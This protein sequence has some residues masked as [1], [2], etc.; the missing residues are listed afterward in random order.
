[1]LVILFVVHLKNYK[2]FKF[3]TIR[4]NRPIFDENDHFQEKD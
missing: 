1:M 2:N 3:S 4:S